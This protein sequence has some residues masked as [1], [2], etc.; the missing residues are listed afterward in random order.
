MDKWQ[1]LCSEEQ[2]YSFRTKAS[3][4]YTAAGT[5]GRWPLSSTMDDHDVLLFE[6][7]GGIRGHKTH[8]EINEEL[9]QL[10]KNEIISH[11]RA[12]K[13]LNTMTVN[14]LKLIMILLFLA[15]VTSM[16]YFFTDCS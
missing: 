13:D 3:S 9:A 14:Q 1:R 10:L 2:H 6:H 12:Y 4:E 7:M 11:G 16:Y 8:K 15:S 5:D